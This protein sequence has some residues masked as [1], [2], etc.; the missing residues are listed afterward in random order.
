MQYQ[1]RGKS[2]QETDVM[3]LNAELLDVTEE[4]AQYVASVRFFGQIRE[5]ANAA[6]ET[7]DELWHLTKPADGGRGWAVAGIQQFQ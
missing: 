2:V 6:P 7:F 3:A 5:E 4:A 1:E